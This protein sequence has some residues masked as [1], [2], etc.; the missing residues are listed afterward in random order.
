MQAP[1]STAIREG[2][3]AAPVLN[4][5]AAEAVRAGTTV[6]EMNSDCRDCPNTA[7]P[8]QLLL[9]RLGSLRGQWR[10]PRVPQCLV[11]LTRRTAGPPGAPVQP[12][13][14]QLLFHELRS[15]RAA[16]TLSIC[17]SLCSSSLLSKVTSKVTINAN[18]ETNT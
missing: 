10:V 9:A 17:L 3:T 15:G 16:S 4:P 1:Y 6:S 2:S 14:L 5:E 11:L 8:S 12:Q 18:K 7:E 13:P